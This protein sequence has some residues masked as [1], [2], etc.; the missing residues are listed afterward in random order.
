M[1]TRSREATS[2]AAQESAGR[3]RVIASVVEGFPAARAAVGS[4]GYGGR[5]GFGVVGGGGWFGLRDV[6]VSKASHPPVPPSGAT[7]R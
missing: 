6:G 2:G 1:A 4:R 5:V 3:S 7:T